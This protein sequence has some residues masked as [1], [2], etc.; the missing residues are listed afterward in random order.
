MKRF[1]V[2]LTGSS[3][4]LQHRM[5]EEEILKLLGAKDTKK[6]IKQEFTPREMAERYAYRKGTNYVLPLEYIRSAFRGASSEYKQKHSSRK[7][8]K[9]I[10]ASIFRPIGDSAPLLDHKN[11]KII[12]FEVDIQKATNHLK[13]AVAVC[14]PRFDKWKSKFQVMIDDDL[15]SE[16]MAL[17]I[18]QDAGRR[19]GIGSF[20]IVCGGYFGA[21]EVTKFQPPKK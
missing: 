8:Y 7:S 18:L 21:F 5:P 16:E 19:V 13:G 10:A 20:R 15:I 17:Q 4:L 12:K 11:K 1:D 2:E 6:K 14:R 3:P 9:S